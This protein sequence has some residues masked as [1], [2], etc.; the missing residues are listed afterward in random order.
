MIILMF[1]TNFEENKYNIILYSMSSR[2]SNWLVQ[3]GGPVPMF[4]FVRQAG[5]RSV[6]ILDRGW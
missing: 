6:H 2:N 1:Q 5:G 4:S 3:S